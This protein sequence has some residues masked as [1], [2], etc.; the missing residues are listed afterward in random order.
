MNY[1]EDVAMEAL[2]R[3]EQQ[4]DSNDNQEN[5]V[6]GSESDSNEQIEENGSD[7]KSEAENPSE[8][9]L[10][11]NKDDSDGADEDE[12]DKKDEEP[13]KESEENK[14]SDK[15]EDEKQELSDEE[16]EELA[17]KRGYSKKSDEDKQKEDEEAGRKA[18]D[19]A[20]KRPK[21]VDRD[22][23]EAMPP[24]NKVIYN[25]LPYIQAVGKDGNI[26]RVKT[27]QQLPDDF[28]FANKKAEMQFQNDL[29]AQ[30]M[31]AQRMS[32]A[33]NERISQNRQRQQS[34]NEARAILGEIDTLQKSGDLPIPKA[35][36]GTKEFDSDEAV[37][38]INKVLGYRQERLKAGANLSVE[39]ALT[40]YKAKHPD[41]F[42]SKSEAKG[43]S[44]RKSIAKKIS[45]SNK[46]ADT[47]ISAK[48]SA[49][50]KYY[51]YGMSME[52]VLDRALDEMDD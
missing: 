48:K 1:L 10:E 27:A 18:F 15:K 7:T 39:D 11:G 14:E 28:E 6:Q 26:V 45:G 2:D 4:A 29:Q 31:K 19:N 32:D 40:I 49:G 51:R 47:S 12:E 37:M 17:K 20:T 46:S 25:N 33:I 42:K 50:P 5:A 24:I 41:E 36:P 16:F 35:K 43:D 21:E 38:L 9:E 3:Q 30:E 22:T 52:D 8:S 13:E 23:W 44:E 34:A